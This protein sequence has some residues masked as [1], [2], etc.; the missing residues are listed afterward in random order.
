DFADILAVNDAVIDTTFRCSPAGLIPVAV[1]NNDGTFTVKAEVDT[2]PTLNVMVMNDVAAEHLTDPGI[3]RIMRDAAHTSGDLEV[4]YTLSGTAESNDYTESHTGVATITDGNYWVDL[5]FSAIN[6]GID[7]GVETIEVELT[8]DNAYTLGTVTTGSIVINEPTFIT[9]HMAL[10]MEPDGNVSLSRDGVLVST[11]D[12]L[13]WSVYNFTEGT[14]VALNDVVRTS[15]N[16]FLLASA[17]GKYLVNVEITANDRYFKFELLNVSNTYG[18]EL[19]DDWPGHRVE[20]DLNIT[21]QGDGWQLNTL[22]LNPLSELAGPLASSIGNGIDFL[23]PYP[24]LAQTT[25]QP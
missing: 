22:L 8:A 25:D 6:D 2:G 10:T 11:T 1:D 12:S 4:F 24:H 18:G 17:D 14:R 15:T 23:W 19:D 13:G 20:F 5:D 21:T 16:E 9:T 3:I 7:E